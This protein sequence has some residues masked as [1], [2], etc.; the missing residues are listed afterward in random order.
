MPRY[1]FHYRDADDRLMEDR[2]GSHQA[3]LAAVEHEAQLVAREILQEEI[4]D[5]G[6]IFAPRCLEIENEAGQVVLYLPFW[7]SVAPN[8]EVEKSQVAS[9]HRPAES[10]H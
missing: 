6:P 3:S 2:L 4:N 9:E 5:G 8:Q 1:F 10:A 7:A